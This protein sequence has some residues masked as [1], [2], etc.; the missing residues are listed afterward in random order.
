MKTVD[1]ELAIAR[2]LDYRAR[3]IVPNVFWGLGFRHELDLCVMSE[4]G[5]LT[6]IE[7][8]V[9][10][11]DLKNDLQKKHKHHDRRNRIKYL[12]FAMPSNIACKGWKYVP[13]DAGLFVVNKKGMVFEIAKPAPR[14]NAKPLSDKERYTLCKLAT[15]RIWS[16]KSKLLEKDELIRHLQN[17]TR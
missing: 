17:K 10:I 6:E 13:Q 3:V 12:Y 7:I 2:K 9:S 8:K 11:A 1:I 4:R 16:L 15:P 5:Y 14:V